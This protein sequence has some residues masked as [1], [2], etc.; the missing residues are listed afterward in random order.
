M[1]NYIPLCAG[2]EKIVIGRF[3]ITLTTIK[4]LL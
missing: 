1:A 4:K 2:S 3:Y